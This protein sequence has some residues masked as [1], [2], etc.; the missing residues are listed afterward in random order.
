M[1]K[2]LLGKRVHHKQPVLQIVDFEQK[3]TSAYDIVRDDLKHCD[4]IETAIKI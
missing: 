3:I 2:T 1:R 4:S